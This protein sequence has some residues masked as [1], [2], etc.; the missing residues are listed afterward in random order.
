MRHPGEV[1][2][3]PPDAAEG[4]D[5]KGRRHVLLTACE[6]RSDDCTLAYASTSEAEAVFGAAFIRLDPSRT[7]RGRT[8]RM[9]FDRVT[10]V[11]PS[12]LVGA[13][14]D[15]MRRR[16]GRLTD[17]RAELRASLRKALGIGAGTAATAAVTCR[18]R[19][20]RLAQ[21]VRREI[22]CSHALIVTEPFYSSQR[23]YQV[24][25]PL[26]D[27]SEFESTDTD[28][29]VEGKDWL[30]LVSGDSAPVAFAVDLIQTVF[31]PT[32]IE[33]ETVAVVDGNTVA[34]VEQRLLQLFDL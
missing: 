1:W 10:Y 11:Y 22:E 34:Q 18:G 6:E 26:L 4:G 29:V 7:H 15:E 14:A 19:V 20:V 28:V 23:R 13:G 25:V 31:H 27:T 9:G 32:E 33:G 30:S 8:G 21:S 24:V 16:V 3:L 12:R 5:G 2:F 17:E